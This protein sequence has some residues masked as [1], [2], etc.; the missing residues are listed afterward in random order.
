[1]RVLACP[2]RDDLDEVVLTML[3]HLLDPAKYDVEIAP[4]KVLAGELLPLVAEKKPAVVVIGSLPPG[5][6]AH[7]RYVCK[8]LRGQFPDLRILVGRWGAK[9]GDETIERR[10]KA[11]GADHA[12]TTLLGTRD[13]LHTW[14]PVLAETAA[15]EAGARPLQAASA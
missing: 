3:Q 11:A 9:G 2:A 8:R 12:E 1:L 7:T 15:A 10:L 6:L 4:A 5:G 13:H 14:L